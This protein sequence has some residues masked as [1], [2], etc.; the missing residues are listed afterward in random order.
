MQYRKSKRQVYLMNEDMRARY[1]LG[2]NHNTTTQTIKH[3][4]HERGS[5]TRPWATS[6]DRHERSDDGWMIAETAEYEPQTA[7]PAT[8]HASN[9]LIRGTYHATH[10]RRASDWPKTMRRCHAADCG[11]RHVDAT[12]YTASHS[13]AELSEP[14]YRPCTTSRRRNVPNT[15]ATR[16][17]LAEDDAPR[18]MRRTADSVS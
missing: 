15:P 17:R 4:S 12:V 16:V 3:L 18:P 5:A 6:S 9:E 1:L 10:Q 11:L 8:T 2:I 7:V 14:A 13:P